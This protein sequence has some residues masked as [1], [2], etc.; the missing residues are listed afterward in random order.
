MATLTVRAPGWNRYSGQRSRVPPARSARTGARTI[1]FFMVE[2]LRSLLEECP[3]TC[4]RFSDL[5]NCRGELRSELS[6]VGAELLQRRGAQGMGRDRFQ[7]ERIE[8]RPVVRNAVIEMRPRGQTGHPDVG[9]DLPLPHARSG[10]N[11]AAESGEVEVRGFDPG[12]VADLHVVSLAAVAGGLED[13]TVGRDHDGRADRR[14]IVDAMMRA[15]VVKDRV[16]AAVGERRGDAGEGER[17]AEELLAE[18]CAVRGVVA[19]APVRRLVAEGLEGLAV[20]REVRRQD[21][22]V[23]DVVG[24][25]VFLPNHDAERIAL[26]QSEEVDVP[27]EG[28]DELRD[29]VWLLA[30][31]AHG[32][33]E[34]AVDPG[35]NR[36]ANLMELCWSGSD[37]EA[38][39]AADG[40]ELAPA[41][42]FHLHAVDLA[43]RVIVE[44]QEIAGTETAEVEGA[45]KLAI[46]EGAAGAI[47]PA[48]LED[49]VERVVLFDG[50]QHGVLGQDGRAEPR[51]GEV[52]VPHSRGGDHGRGRSGRRRPGRINDGDRSQ[53][54]WNGQRE[55]HGQIRPRPPYHPTQLFP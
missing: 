24:S 8:P 20:V 26:R 35:G 10:A 47:E 27:L 13:D 32:L 15:E 6:H 18:R 3:S 7:L 36:G 19:G 17:G 34:R 51:G 44:A 1:T 5:R 54:E 23:A 45:A 12:R 33:V 41:G 43:G 21:G 49:A 31:A 29:E 53:N 37:L 46:Q 48:G 11:P 42:H 14:A 30:G 52:V 38:V 28:I 39:R 2:L 22:S 50:Q 16:K 9:D 40:V 55:D 25:G 4:I